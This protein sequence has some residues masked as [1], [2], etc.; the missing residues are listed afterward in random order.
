MAPHSDVPP[1][2]KD[3][4]VARLARL[5]VEARALA[6][7]ASVIPGQAERW[8]LPDA[9]DTGASALEECRSR[10]LIEYDEMMVWYRHEL[11]RVAVRDSIPPERYRQ[12][13]GELVSAMAEAGED[14]ARITHHARAAGD[15]A[16]VVRFAPRAAREAAAASAHREALAHYRVAA[17]HLGLLDRRDQAELLLSYAVESYL[18]NEAAEA[19]DAA[20][21]A[22]ELWRSE[23]ER[24]PE[25]VTLRL[26]SRLHWWLG[27]PEAAQQTG[28]EAVAVLEGIDNSDELPMAYSNLAQLAMLAQNAATAEKWGTK[29]IESARTRN[30]YA[31]L[32]HALN[33]L[34]STRARRG[35]LAGLDMLEESLQVALDHGLDDHV[36]R[37]YANLVWTLLDYRRFE[38]ASHLLDEGMEFCRKRELDGSLYYLTAERARLRLALGDWAEAERDVHWVV[39]RPEQP[40]IPQ[41]PAL[42]VG[43]LLGVRRGDEDADARLAAAWEMAEPTGE[44]QRMGP[45]AVARAEAA[46]LREDKPG[47]VSAIAASYRLAVAAGQPWV[48]DEM[49]FWMWRGDGALDLPLRRDT[50]YLLQIDGRWQEAADAWEEIGCPYERALALVDSD[51][52]DALLE[53]LQILDRL[54]A[55]PAARLVRNRL[56]KLGVSS[57]PR[58]PRP[59]TRAN[60]LGLTPRQLDVLELLAC[61]LTNVEIAERL[62]VSPKTVD[63]HVSAVLLKLGVKSRREATKVAEDLGLLG[64]QAE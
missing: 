46:W 3:A 36:G 14:V 37:G 27:Q 50:P 18:T 34:G 6:E 42:A 24:E 56:R 29:A 32:A 51:Q 39:D 62:F 55:A 31:T 16:A 20:T 7:S 52:P 35:E 11:V 17:K 41:L 57:V 40:G 33:N 61:G 25:G 44:L 53:A 48:L 8:L 26:L 58:G 15:H 13:N 4:A 59:E 47:V 63:H 38:V 10:G 43:S 12:L 2:I 22:L 54:G 30:D 60:P 1:S 19:M 64:P 49:A 5:S 45:I 28:R 23:R 9:G 21:A